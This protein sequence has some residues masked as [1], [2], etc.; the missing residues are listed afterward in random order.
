VRRTRLVGLLALAGA[1]AAPAAA[2]AALP[3]YGSLTPLGCVVDQNAADTKGCTK[4]AGVRGLAY[5]AI[6]PD[7]RFVYVSGR[8]EAAITVLARDRATGLLTRRSCVGSANAAPELKCALAPGLTYP[9]GL[10]VSPDGKSLYAAA[11]NGNELLAFARNGRT[12]ALKHL[13]CFT[14]GVAAEPSCTQVPRLSGP[15]GVVVSPEGRHV[16]VTS[17]DAGIIIFARAADGSLTFAGCMQSAGRDG[18]VPAPSLAYPR[19]LAIS[20]DGAHVYAAESTGN[21]IVAFRRDGTS[22]ALTQIGCWSGLSDGRGRSANCTPAT[23]VSY[24]E[25][26]AISPDGAHVYLTGNAN[27]IAIFVRDPAT[28]LLT[29]PPGVDGCITDN[30]EPGDDCQTSDGLDTTYGLAFDPTGSHLYTGA[31]GSGSVGMFDRDPATGLLR[32]HTPCFSQSDPVCT[33]RTPMAHAGH[34]LVSPDGRHVYVAAPDSSSLQ[35]FGRSAAAPVVKPRRPTLVLK[36]GRGT[37]QMAC[38]RDALLGCFGTVL[39]RVVD[40]QG[41][42]VGKGRALPFD[43]APRKIAKLRF[44]LDARSR[45]AL[46]ATSADVAL[47]EI[48]SRSPSTSITYPAWLRLRGS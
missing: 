38:P 27:S 19:W 5:S 6:S 30:V 7:G 8:N 41:R 22:G 17:Y 3:I 48:T 29:Q 33:R 12:G 31:Y 40:G 42:A 9:A 16:Y 34:V 25:H 20:P 36:R 43:V 45:D 18:C 11:S 14:T 21:A 28:G 26:V 2:R 23:G 13:G 44:R 47:V 39:V 32:R 4:V 37:L 24:A 15:I 1:L 35:V 46:A 10:A